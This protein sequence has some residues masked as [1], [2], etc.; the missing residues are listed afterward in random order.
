MRTKRSGAVQ[1]HAAGWLL[2]AL[3]QGLS[4]LL[5]PAPLFAQSVPAYH[6]GT[7]QPNDLAKFQRNGQIRDPG[8]VDG[9]NNGMG[10]NP[11]SATDNHQR[12]ICS[13]SAATTGPYYQVCIGHN[14]AGDGLLTVDNLNGA[15][16]KG[17]K[18]FVNGAEIPIAGAPPAAAACAN[19]L[20]H[21]GDPAGVAN[22]DAAFASA[23][24]NPSVNGPCVY[25]P[26]GTYK[27]AA[28]AV[29]NITLNQKA[30]RVVGDG[31]D[32]SKL[33]WTGGGGIQVN[34]N[35]RQSRVAVD[36]LTLLTGSSNTGAGVDVQFSVHN[37]NFGSSSF[38]DLRIAG[39]VDKTNYWG[40][41]IKINGLSMVNY[42][43]LDLYGR[44]FDANGIGLAAGLSRSGGSSTNNS[45]IHNIVNS[46]FIGCDAGILCGQ[47][48]QGLTV[49][50]S[51]LST[52][53]TASERLPAAGR[54]PSHNLP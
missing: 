32:L 22:N 50:N 4:L 17:F 3:F 31:K 13:N 36:G 6:M 12:G 53:S 41:A 34:S 37:N 2:P 8:G 5:Y 29:I 1:D 40:A 18:L 42:D 9:D 27:F 43:G 51:I 24:A 26:A 7:A 33:I 16:P 28:Q 44:L 45:F 11:F 52:T 15:P 35:Q 21:G 19:I 10:V 46:N 38:R 39:I 14:T 49:V 48:V 54:R 20:V 47:Y 23:V 30:A 25:F